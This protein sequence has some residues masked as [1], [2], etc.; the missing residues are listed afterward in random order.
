MN[1]ISFRTPTV[2]KKCQEWISYAQ[3]GT[4]AFDRNPPTNASPAPFVSTMLSVGTLSLP[5]A[6]VTML[7]LLWLG[8][9]ASLRFRNIAWITQLDSERL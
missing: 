1:D 9:N 4:I 2:A 8:G 6:A 3:L 7:G 5:E